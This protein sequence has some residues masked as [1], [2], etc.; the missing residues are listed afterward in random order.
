MPE[1]TQQT[2][3]R[4]WTLRSAGTVYCNRYQRN[5][6]VHSARTARSIDLGDNADSN[7]DH[8]SDG[9]NDHRHYSSR[10][11]LADNRAAR[12][13]AREEEK[14]KSGEKR[15]RR[16]PEINLRDYDRMMNAKHIYPAPEARRGE[17]D[18]SP[19]FLFRQ[20]LQKILEFQGV[21]LSTQRAGRWL[22][23]EIKKV[24]KLLSIKTRWPIIQ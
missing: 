16:F 1:E 19:C 5:A 15:K 4:S 12:K 22:L 10:N 6:Q 18:I 9:Q 3:S 13:V 11:G 7:D 8:E 24:A 2:L 23:A 20:V 14:K 21:F 17:E